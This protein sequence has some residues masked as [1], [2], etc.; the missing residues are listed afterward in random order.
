MS[1]LYVVLILFTAQAHSA[2][3]L[4]SSYPCRSLS[5]TSDRFQEEIH[6]GGSVFAL[7]GRQNSSNLILRG[8]ECLKPASL[9]RGS[10]EGE[11]GGTEK[12][13][14]QKDEAKPTTDEKSRPTTQS[15]D[16][17]SD[18]SYTMDETGKCP[19]L[20]KH[21]F[22]CSLCGGSDEQ[23]NCK[24]VSPWQLGTHKSLFHS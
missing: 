15:G 21:V 18:E 19:D 17:S 23:G 14:Q 2:D 16:S 4:S 1:L 12:Q 10:S 5:R 20:T 7:A 22:L 11:G 6:S 9:T 8:L 13:P 24:G 3:T